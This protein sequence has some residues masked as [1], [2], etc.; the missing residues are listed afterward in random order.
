MSSSSHTK[1]EFYLEKYNNFLN[2][3]KTNILPL[4]KDLESL[5]DQYS[6]QSYEDLV[7]YSIK[8]LKP[9][10]K[11]QNSSMLFKNFARNKLAEY[12]VKVDETVI[13]KLARYFEL[14]STI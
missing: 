3:I 6:K 9:I 10:S 1:S 2:Y 11:M 13:S 14:F 7:S 8:Y 4:N 5:Y 12:N